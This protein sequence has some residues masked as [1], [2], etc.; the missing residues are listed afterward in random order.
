M[1]FWIIEKSCA[2]AHPERVG[3]KDLIVAASLAS[4]PEFRIIG[5][6]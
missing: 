5:Q 4:L 2:K 6:E 1:F 3:L